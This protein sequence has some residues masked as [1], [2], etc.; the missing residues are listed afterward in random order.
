QVKQ[1]A[2]LPLTVA[3]PPSMSRL[4]LAALPPLGL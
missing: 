2:H 4:A 3:H 1:H